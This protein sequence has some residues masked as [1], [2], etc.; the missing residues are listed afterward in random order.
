MRAQDD[1]SVGRVRL[2]VWLD[3][4]CLFKTRS[5]A[6]RA[7]RGGKV[8]VNAQRA[9]PHRTVEAGDRLAINRPQGRTQ[10]VVVIALAAQH[11]PKAA[12]RALYD[13]VT[14]PPSPEAVE[15]RRM[16]G[17]LGTRST[18]PKSAPDKRERRALQRLKRLQG[19]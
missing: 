18:G 2:D 3:V 4:T 14:P 15:F 19:Q 8:E 16:G 17:G 13:D 10:Q 6:Q 11:L 1:V 5:E 7:C 12:A 9:K